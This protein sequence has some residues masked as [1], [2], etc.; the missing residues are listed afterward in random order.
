MLIYKNMHWVFLKPI[1]L[2]TRM[3]HG[4]AFIKVKSNALRMPYQSEE[5]R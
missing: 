2:L 5:L 1:Q 4:Q 3:L